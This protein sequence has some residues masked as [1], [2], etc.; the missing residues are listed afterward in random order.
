MYYICSREYLCH[1]I[2]KDHFG[3]SSEIKTAK[4]KYNENHSFVFVSQVAFMKWSWPSP[5]LRIKHSVKCLPLRKKLS[6]L[7]RRCWTWKSYCC[8][9]TSYFV[10]RLYVGFFT[11]PFDRLSFSCSP[12]FCCFSASSPL[13]SATTTMPQCAAPTIRTTRTRA[14]CA[15]MPASS[16]LKYLLCQKAP[17]LLVCT[18]RWCHPRKCMHNKY[19]HA[20]TLRCTHSPE[21][22]TGHLYKQKTYRAFPAHLSVGIQMMQS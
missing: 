10:D 14:S 18:F 8:L 2:W 5:R 3:V 6:W 13:C 16:S 4:H 12:V 7:S 19:S 1:S 15:G 20:Q 22:H 11:W 17:V 9:N 21:A